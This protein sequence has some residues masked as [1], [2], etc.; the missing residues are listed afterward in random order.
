MTDYKD[1][2][3]YGLQFEAMLAMGNL[4][5]VMRYESWTDDEGVTWPAS[6]MWGEHSLSTAT[7]VVLDKVVELRRQRD[8]A[9]ELAEWCRANHEDAG[10]V[11]FPWEL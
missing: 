9:R 4:A 5:L 2:M 10:I 3:I 6:A 11:T 7:A 1:S 8:E